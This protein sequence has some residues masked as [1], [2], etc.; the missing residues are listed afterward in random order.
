[1][2]I[3]DFGNSSD[4]HPARQAALSAFASRALGRPDLEELVGEGLQLVLDTLGAS[5]VRLLEASGR[6]MVSWVTE[7]RR[8]A[9]DPDPS[10][11][12]ELHVPAA[13]GPV[14]VRDVLLVPVRT[15]DHGAS[16]LGIRAC[17]SSVD[18]DGVAFAVEIAAILAAAIDVRW[19]EDALRWRL[20]LDQL[21]TEV[22]TSFIHLG[23][24]DLGD[25]SS[26]ALALVGGFVGADRAVL[27]LDGPER[28]D[29]F[30]SWS[31]ADAPA[32]GAGE[33]RVVL[34]LDA[35]GHSIGHLAFDLGRRTPPWRRD[36]ATALHPLADV[37][38]RAVAYQQHA[39]ELTASE[40]RYRSLVEEVRDVIVR[41]DA[42][43]RIGFVNQAWTELTGLT[44][45]ETLGRDSFESI[46][47]EDRL[48]A[49][50]H[51]A[52]V[53]RGE[54]NAARSVR[55]IAKD[56]SS[57]WME[58][59]GRALF[60]DDGD[61]A[62]LSGVLHDVTDNKIADDKI[63]AALDEAVHAREEAERSSQA[64]SEFLSRMSHE[65]RTPLNAILGFTQLLEF[66]R[67]EE[68]DRDSLRL[69]TQAG[70]HLLNLI[71]DALDISRVDTGNLTLAL[72]AV[73]VGEVWQDCVNL[74]GAD[75]AAQQVD[76]VQPEPAG[77]PAVHADRQRLT[78]VL[79]NL[80]SNAIKYNHDGGTVTLSCD[81]LDAGSAPDSHGWVRI[82]VSDTGL[83]LPED[84]LDDVFV[85][86]NR[87]GAEL[88]DVE[89]SG[90]GL[91]LTRSLVEA[92]SGRIGLTSIQGSGSTFYVDLPMTTQAP[93]R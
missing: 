76:I 55:F 92:M 5:E 44:L 54:D 81:V 19:T 65:L 73:P 4:V 66:A 25:A 43:G 22:S 60:D 91:A 24:D 35:P 41:V 38:A 83:G 74:L 39:A 26:R 61:F 18:D 84:R 88:T 45:E 1:M 80:L 16:L 82:S 72:E 28:P 2:D 36:V 17:G 3:T 33:T 62:G 68:E 63:R 64:K 12:D 56:G 58:V 86:F 20:Q 42:A 69:I 89:G 59:K 31:R 90:I 87:L 53:M 32:T 46:H 93:A 30:A 29:T 75:A 48:V 23:A 6:A 10:A 40:S 49:A 77:L 79:V 57:R 11:W 70:Q 9:G 14:L 27:H 67:L 51:I 71:N 7:P 13:A 34:S 50:E 15:R 47:P 21:L 85:P 8:A 52:S 37:F 78:Q